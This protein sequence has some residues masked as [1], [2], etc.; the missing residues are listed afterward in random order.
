MKIL[1]FGKNGQ[2]GWELQRS[3]APLGQLIALSSS[4]KELCGNL[5]N[6]SGIAQTIQ[7][8]S[9]DVIVNAAAYTA[10]DKAENESELA[11]IINAQAPGVMAHEATKSKAWLIHY[12]TDYVFDG[13]GHTPR[14]E[15]EIAKPLNVYGKTKLEGEKNITQTGCH[16][17]IFRTSWVYSTYGNNFI[18]T[19]LRLAQERDELKII[20]DQIG[21]PTGAELLA[22][23]T[24]QIVPITKQHSGI[25]GIYHLASQGNTSWHNYARFILAYALST[26]LPLKTQPDSVLPIASSEFPT[27]AKR[28]HN[29]RLNTHKFHSAFGLNL[30]N[31]EI[32]VTRTLT[33]LIGTP[34]NSSKKHS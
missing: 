21:A 10:V 12:S 3:L 27:P 19:I 15:T 7:K 24:A 31:W 11:H 5:T 30:P 32:G 18:K 28:P 20:N 6:L 23:V 26:N 29:S 1:L 8:V 14:S 25:S 4:S 22:D 33:E 9:P 2:V 16:H 13:S 17:L 34:K